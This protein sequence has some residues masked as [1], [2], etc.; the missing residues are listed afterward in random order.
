VLGWICSWLYFGLLE[1]S[2]LQGTLGKAALNIQ[3]TDLHGRRISFG[4]ATG[5]YFGKWISGALF[6]IGYLIQPFTRRRQTLHDLMA[7][8]LV[9]RR[10]SAGS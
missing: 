4:R 2:K 10:D 3:V 5:R 7:G 6:L 1:S 8:T 9:V